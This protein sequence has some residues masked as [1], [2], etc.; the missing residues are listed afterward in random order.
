MNTTVKII[1][2]PIIL[3]I[4]TFIFI[5]LD[6]GLSSYKIHQVFQPLVF[7]VS[8]IVCVFCLNIRKYI[9]TFSISLLLLMVVTYLFNALAVSNWIGSLGFGML[10]IALFAY[11]PE[12]IKKGN[13]EKF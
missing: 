2:I 9:I 1:I 5:V 10:F 8:V 12:V 3:A 6:T 13:I 11:I 4:L 7:A